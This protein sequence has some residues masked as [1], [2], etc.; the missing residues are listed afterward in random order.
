MYLNSTKIIEFIM[1]FLL[2]QNISTELH[3]N[4]EG[5]TIGLI[6]DNEQGDSLSYFEPD[7]NNI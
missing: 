5:I 3:R 4:N 6:S 7:E 1:K 2:S